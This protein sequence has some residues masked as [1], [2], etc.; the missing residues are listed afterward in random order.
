MGKGV[1]CLVGR[2][3]GSIKGMMERGWERV[4]NGFTLCKKFYTRRGHFYYV[5][6]VTRRNMILRAVALKDGVYHI[7]G[8]PTAVA[9]AIEEDIAYSFREV[10]KY[11][12]RVTV[13]QVGLVEG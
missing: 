4:E 7:Y 2:N 12:E 6:I 3:I 11:D 1:T 13:A 9:K 5:N 10:G 8:V